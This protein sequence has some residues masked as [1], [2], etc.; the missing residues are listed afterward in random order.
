MDITT[1]SGVLSTVL[2]IGKLSN[3][4]MSYRSGWAVHGD[5]FTKHI[6]VSNTLYTQ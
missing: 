4:V 5:S 3:F 1:E 6:S 2:I